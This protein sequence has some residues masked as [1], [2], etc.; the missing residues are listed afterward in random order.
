MIRVISGPLL[1]ELLISWVALDK[2][3]D[4]STKIT[5]SLAN[6]SDHMEKM[7]DT[8]FEYVVQ[9]DHINVISFRITF[10]ARALRYLEFFYFTVPIYML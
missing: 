7:S 8:G 1:T 10:K 3:V 9:L 2:I 6:R 4:C 5:T